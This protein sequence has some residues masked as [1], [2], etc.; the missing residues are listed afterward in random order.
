MCNIGFA[1]PEA[2]QALSL[3]SGAARQGGVHVPEFGMCRV[4]VA[5]GVREAEEND[6]RQ[7]VF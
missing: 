7:T 5:P 4:D 2:C 3:F 6:E 1:P